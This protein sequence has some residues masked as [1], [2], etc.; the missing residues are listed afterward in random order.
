MNSRNSVLT[1]PQTGSSAAA[2][3]SMNHIAAPPNPDKNFQMSFT[4]GKL[5]KQQLEES[6]VIVSS[7]NHPSVFTDMDE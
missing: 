7:R 3:F 4:T 6:K 5:L 1:R 2:S